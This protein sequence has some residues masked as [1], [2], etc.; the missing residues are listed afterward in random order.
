MQAR[1]YSPAQRIA[2]IESA[3]FDKRAHSRYE[4]REKEKERLKV[5]QIQEVNKRLEMIAAQ[6]DRARALPQQMDEARE[7]EKT[8][9]SSIGAD[10]K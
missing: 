10:G 8:R 6:Q 9:R 3:E 5:S 7:H 1:V 4:E 2:R